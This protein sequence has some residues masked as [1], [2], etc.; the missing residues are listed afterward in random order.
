VRVV[1]A[2]AVES[3]RERRKTEDRIWKTEDRRQKSEDRFAE[4]QQRDVQ[5]F[6]E[7]IAVAEYAEREKREVQVMG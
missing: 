4:R 6:T 2:A 1:V 5:V 3:R 7:R